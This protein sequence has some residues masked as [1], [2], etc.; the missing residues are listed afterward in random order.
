MKINLAITTIL[1]ALSFQSQAGITHTTYERVVCTG[2]NAKM[3]FSMPTGSYVKGTIPSA[4]NHNNTVV[5]LED[6]ATINALLD[7]NVIRKTDFDP[8]PFFKSIG[9]DA[10][11]FTDRVNLLMDHK[12]RVRHLSGGKVDYAPVNPMVHPDTIINPI[13][14]DN[15]ISFKSQTRLVIH[16]E[17]DSAGQMSIAFD[18]IEPE[19]VRCIE[20]GMIK[21]PY[22]FEDST[23]TTKSPEFLEACLKTEQVIASKTIRVLS[24]SIAVDECAVQ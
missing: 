19:V 4:A 5:H 15:M 18:V 14:V 10:A 13:S 2:D 12:L 22:F 23:S 16:A 8:I 17:S 11:T 9:I 3:F 7:L 6:P 24:T 1:T 21:N 20:K